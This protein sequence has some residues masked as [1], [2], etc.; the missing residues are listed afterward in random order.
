MEFDV[1]THNVKS[2]E[3]Q[4]QTVFENHKQLLYDKGGKPKEPMQEPI[5]VNNADWYSSYNF[6]EFVSLVGRHFRMGNMLSRASVQSRLNSEQGMSF[7]EFTYQI[8]QAYDW[9]HLM[10][11]YN[12]KFQLGGSDQMGNIVSGHELIGRVMKKEVFG[13]TLPL[14]TNEEGD[15]FGK[16]AGNAVWLDANKT[17]EFSFYQFFVRLSDVEAENLLKLLTFLPMNEV[18]DLIEKHRRTPEFREAQKAIAEH[19]T[20]LVHGEE[21]LKKALTVSDALYKG[22]VQALGALQPQEIPQLFAG[23]SYTELFMEPGTTMMTAALRIKC[24][25]SE[26]DANRIISAGG[27]YIN[28]KRTTNPVEILS[29]EIH[30]LPNGVSLFRVG[31]KNYHVVRWL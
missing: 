6:V 14:I 22:N 25:P 16:S 17:S 28:Q 19:L 9:L 27:F 29:P 10:Q 4:I 26:Y 11:T 2:I 23:A 13:L 1:I 30:V 8:F 7:T 20:L 18:N 21:G 3:K 15:K 24:F 5:I 12:C 31:K